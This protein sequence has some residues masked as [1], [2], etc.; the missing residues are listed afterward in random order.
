MKPFPVK[1]QK[2]AG[3]S[4]KEVIKKAQ[5]YFSN[6]KRKTK[7]RTYIRSAYF[8]KQKIFFTHFWTHLFQKTPR[9]RRQRLAFLPCAVELIKKCRNE[10]TTK[11]NPNK[12]SEMLHRFYGITKEKEVFFVQIKENV[13]TDRKELMSIV[14][15]ND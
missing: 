9:R 3:S 14:V 2:L 5:R 4:D 13:N 1:S 7:R 10:P 11:T 6:I 12:K 8:G 15:P